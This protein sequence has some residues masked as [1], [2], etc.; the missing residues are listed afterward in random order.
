VCFTAD[1]EHCLLNQRLAR[2]IPIEVVPE[3]VLVVFKSKWFRRFI[4][5][6]NTGSLIQHMFTSQL[7]TFAF[8][9]PPIAEQ[10]RIVAEVDRRLS[11]VRGVETQVDANF[12]RV[13]RLRQSI[14]L[15][16]FSGTLTSELRTHDNRTALG[17]A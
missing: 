7:A 16:A 14:L 12:Q 3:F 17:A 6:L 8:P 10:H 9:I 13:E 4:D 15:A 2:L 5:G 11:L 1:G